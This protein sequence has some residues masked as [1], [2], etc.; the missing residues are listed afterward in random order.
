MTD[1]ESKTFFEK[2]FYF[3]RLICTP[4]LTGLPCEED[5]P[6]NDGQKI[7]EANVHSKDIVIATGVHNFISEQL[8]INSTYMAV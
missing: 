6:G 5:K 2:Y 7:I 1:F 3:F 8:N 4:V